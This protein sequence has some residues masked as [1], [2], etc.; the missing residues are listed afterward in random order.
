MQKA[1]EQYSIVQTVQLDGGGDSHYRME[2]PAKH[3]A[4][5][6]PAWRVINVD[7]HAL[8]RFSLCEKADLLVIYQSNDVDLFPIIRR[9][10]QA[11]KK[12]LIEFNDNFYD[13]PASSPVFQKWSSFQI[14]E[15]YRKLIEN[16]DALIVTGEGLNQLFAGKLDVPIHILPNQLALSPEPLKLAKR[17]ADGKFHVG[18]AGSG[19]H[20]P[21]ILSI[22][23]VIRKLMDAI[24]QLT[25]HVM[26]NEAIPYMLKLPPERMTY[27]PWGT[28][29]EYLRFWHKV[30]IGLAPLIDNPYNRCRSDIKAVEMAAGGALPLLAGLLPYQNFLNA[31]GLKSFSSRE[32]LY[33]L[34]ESY[35]KNGD[36]LKE[37]VTKCYNYVCDSRLGS[38]DLSRLLL[39][40]QY[41]PPNP[42]HELAS[43][44]TGYNEVHGTRQ[45]DSKGK[46]AFLAA[47]QAIQNGDESGAKVALELALEENPEDAN[48]AIE[49]IK[50]FWLKDPSQAIRRIAEVK[51]HHPRD[52]RFDLLILAALT[53]SDSLPDEWQSF[54]SRLKQFENFAQTHYRQAVLKIFLP[55]LKEQHRLADAGVELLLLYPR[56]LDLRLAVGEALIARGD[57]LSALEQF[58]ALVA[59]YEALE[60]N[61]EFLGAVT[62]VYLRTWRDALYARC[63]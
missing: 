40:G 27:T 31:T 34:V 50:K 32:E 45:K 52:L 48:L 8:E 47:E 9:R 41:L 12:T 56:S 16:C 36:A 3:L 59:E 2:W 51:K 15:I 17:G 21:D 63:K 5:Q 42:L 46:L 10:R 35:W 6:A 18:W 62:S 49:L 14:R 58:E 60:E 24:P 43:F 11:G 13:P 28:V 23:P 20:F 30:Q 4:K 29:G 7:A 55:Q 39:Y 61:H 44:N 38:K 37:Q 19:G 25:F 22:V 53:A 33:S 1:Q 54:I 26:G 57:D